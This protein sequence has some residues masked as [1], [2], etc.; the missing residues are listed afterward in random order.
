M[1]APN[2]PNYA[3]HHPTVGNGRGAAEPPAG[4]EPNDQPIGSFAALLAEADN[5]RTLLRDGYTRASYLAA[6]IRRYR[7]QSQAVQS[8]IASLRQIH[9]MNP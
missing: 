3:G 6:A 8:A 4:P 2:K 9:Q 1:N 7:K 5:L